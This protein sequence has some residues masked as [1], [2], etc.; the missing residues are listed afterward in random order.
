MDTSGL[1]LDMLRQTVDHF[2]LLVLRRAERIGVLFD[3]KDD[4]SMETAA[5][6]AC[7]NVAKLFSEVEPE[8]LSFC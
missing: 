1:G 2:A 8:R 7:C 4:E 5:V 6:A 3:G